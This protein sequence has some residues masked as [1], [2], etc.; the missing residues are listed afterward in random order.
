MTLFG[1][2]FS[3]LKVDYNSVL[4]KCIIRFPICLK[5]NYSHRSNLSHTIKVDIPPLDKFNVSYSFLTIV[6]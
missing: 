6:F 2:L 5:S 3:F 4:V 1:F